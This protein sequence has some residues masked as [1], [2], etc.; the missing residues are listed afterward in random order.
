[1]TE[2]S[3]DAAPADTPAPGGG[4]SAELSVDP[5]TASATELSLEE[6]ESEIAEAEQLVQEL[7]ARLEQT[8]DDR[9]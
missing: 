9:R 2:Q 7:S 3:Q 8:A 5:A 6:L 1:M 4:T